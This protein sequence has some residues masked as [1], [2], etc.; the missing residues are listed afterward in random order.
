V[1][2]PK[3]SQNVPIWYPRSGND[4]ADVSASATSPPTLRTGSIHFCCPSFIISMDATKC[5]ATASPEDGFSSEDGF[6]DTDSDKLN[7]SSIKQHPY[8]RLYTKPSSHNEPALS[9]LPNVHD[10]IP[11]Y[12]LEWNCECYLQ[13]LEFSPPDA[14]PT[15]ARPTLLC[16]L[17]AKVQG[18]K[19]WCDILDK[20]FGQ[21]K[22]CREVLKSNR[23]LAAIVDKCAKSKKLSRAL[24]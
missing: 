8:K 21:W 10:L 23:E 2:W 1:W 11:F 9:N 19:R 5:R 15:L 4:N 13:C 20:R 3:P 18:N 22:Y 12:I 24:Q 16:T 14:G 7:T 6:S 17:I